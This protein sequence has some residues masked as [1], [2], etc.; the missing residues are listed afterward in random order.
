MEEKNKK[1]QGKKNR[2]AGARF[3]LKVREDLEKEGWIVDKWTNNVE[4]SHL[5][6]LPTR[7]VAAK[8]KFRG[9]G[10]PMMLGAGFPDFICFKHN[11]W[12]NEK[13][14]KFLLGDMK[15]TIIIGV[16]VKL[17]GILKKEEKEKAKWLLD[18]NIFS[19]I[20]IASRGDKCGTI[21][22][23]EFYDENKN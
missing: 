18:N 11:E 9:K 2:Q 12:K 22:Y 1:I 3:E 19:K 14:K 8:H 15:Q 10:I 16:E 7:L 20:L 6:E 13:I 23:K 5:C 17:N 4:F 21:K